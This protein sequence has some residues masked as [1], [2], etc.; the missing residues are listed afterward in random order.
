M[1]QPTSDKSRPNLARICVEVDIKRPKVNR[2]RIGHG[3]FAVWQQ[4]IYEEDPKYCNFCYHIGHEEQICYWKKENNIPIKAT[5]QAKAPEQMLKRTA[6][7][8]GKATLIE[9]TRGLDQ[10]GP[11]KPQIEI[12]DVQKKVQIKNN[13][14]HGTIDPEKS[15]VE[16]GLTEY[17][18]NNP[19]EAL[20]DS[21]MD[22]ADGIEAD[23]EPKV[24]RNG[25]TNIPNAEPPYKE[26]TEEINEKMNKPPELQADIPTDPIVPMSTVTE[27]V[28]VETVEN[29]EK[30]EFN[31]CVD[32]S[33]YNKGDTSDIDKVIAHSIR[34]G[35]SENSLGQTETTIEE[36]FNREIIKSKGYLAQPKL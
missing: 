26:Q 6:Q 23:M 21:N 1:D 31:V 10:S 36:G 15:Y 3:D 19:F 34:R 30:E 32:L 33:R 9:K 2:V 4:V 11:S 12:E 16:D 5:G 22:E 27:D 13:Q 24:Q 25:D 17:V 35:S 7:D 18:P 28:L 20:V 14:A 8:K 29:K